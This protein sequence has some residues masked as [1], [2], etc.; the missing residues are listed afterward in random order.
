MNNVTKM[1]LQTDYSNEKLKMDENG[2]ILELGTPRRSSLQG[3]K[4][5]DKGICQGCDIGERKRH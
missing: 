2:E 3:A 1:V 5:H 4:R